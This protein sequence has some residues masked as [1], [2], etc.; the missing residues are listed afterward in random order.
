VSAVDTEEGADEEVDSPRLGGRELAI[1]AVLAVAAAVASTWPLAAHLQDRAHDGFDPLFQAWQIDW[2]QHWL[3]DGGS[4]LNANIYHPAKSS[5]TFS[6][7]AFS[8]AL[9]LLPLRWAGLTPIGVL[10]VALLLAYAA[11]A[12]AAYILGRYVIGSRAA[13]AVV[14]AAFAFGTYN[15][16]LGQ[17]MNVMFRPGVPLAALGTWILAERARSNRAVAAPM[18]LVAGCIAFQIMTSLYTAVMTLLAV[19]FVALARLPALRRRGLL[20]V[21]AAVLIGVVAVAPVLF[22]YVARAGEG[23]NEWTL[24][25]LD[26][27]GADFLTVDPSLSL[28]GN[29]RASPRDIFGQPTFPGAALL[30]LGIAGVTAYTRRRA[31]VLTAGVLVVGA[32][33]L[34]LGTSNR[35]WRAFMPYRL[36]YDFV[37]FA[38]SLRATGRFWLVGLLGLGILAGLGVDR[39]AS[40][41]ANWRGWSRSTV[42]AVVALVAI[43]AVAAEGHRPWSPLKPVP[44]AAVDD[45]LHRRRDEAAVIY[46]PVPEQKEGSITLL[47]DAKNVYASTRHHRSTVN[48]YG[49]FSP[50]SYSEMLRIMATFPD[51]ASLEYLRSIGV[52]YVVVRNDDGREDALLARVSASR[53]LERL[54][55]FSGNVL[56][57]LR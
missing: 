44:A 17:H 15:S 52:R 41:L 16:F 39:I 21:G 42:A 4:L 8:L 7:P 14:A 10:N 12:V 29:V 25:E 31:V 26:A 2:V 35:G 50:K 54:E 13:S 18:L 27:G 24:R 37:P 46:L 19:G 56:F 1:V 53:Q 43:A 48:G 45:A 23:G 38:S 55:D 5:L 22:V 51:R 33:V 40:A 47:G 3:T 9:L 57:R 11:D 34:A 6:D 32:A 20:T 49:G 36:V 30:L 28:W